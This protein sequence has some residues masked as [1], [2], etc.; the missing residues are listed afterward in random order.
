M[1]LVIKAIRQLGLRPVG[2]L[3]L[4]R[5]SLAS[6]FYRWTENGIEEDNRLSANVF[7]IQKIF[8]LP[9]RDILLACLSKKDLQRLRSEADEIVDGK[10][11]LF[12]GDAV[13]LKLKPEA[14]LSHWTDYETGKTAVDGDIKMTWEP[15]RFGWA[16]TLAR[17]F[18][19]CKDSKYAI[20]FWR[21]TASFLEANPPYKGPQ[22]MSGQ[23]AAL[24]LMGLTFAAQV[25]ASA[26][27][28][29]P[30][31]I[32]ALGKVI[33]V[34][35]RRIV[36]TL[37]YARSQNNNHLLSEA[38]GLITAALVLP[39]HPQASRWLWLGWKWFNQGLETQIND[40]GVYIQ[41]STNYQ[42]LMLQLALWVNLISQHQTKVEKPGDGKIEGS[43]ISDANVKRLNDATFWLMSLV[44]KQS[45]HCPNLGPNDG[46][47]IQPLSL[48]SIDDYRPV[49]Q[50][51]AMIF[52]GIVLPVFGNGAWDEMSVWYGAKAPELEKPKP[53]GKI[54]EGGAP[55]VLRN[56]VSESW[57]YLR[58]ANYQNRPGHAD[59]LHFD[60]WRQGINIVQ[61][62]GTFSYNHPSPWDNTLAKS[63]VHNTITVNG[64]D[65]MTRAGKFLWLDWAQAK[66]VKI[67][68]EENGE[69]WQISAE[70]D[71]YR[72]LG[73]I[74][75][76][77]VSAQTDGS[78]LIEDKL[79]PSYTTKNLEVRFSLRL[80]W[81]FCS[82]PWEW[83]NGS[84]T[85][86]TKKGICTVEIHA[87]LPI[88]QYQIIRGGE[89]LVGQGDFSPTCGWASPTYGKKEP[90]ISLSAVIVAKLPVQIST[91]I[92]FHNY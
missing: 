71:G 53:E 16:Y 48:C 87:D 10:V 85:L 24:R 65:Q 86:F 72:H 88:S 57:G 49:M 78:W 89:L 43:K 52:G 69:F 67:A 12:G 61:D 75:R 1:L 59:Q 77:S 58:I 37:V 54:K 76:R 68:Q 84:L 60:L 74:H 9:P 18:Y 79:T 34:H 40:E 56:P 13:D 46:A 70:H 44:D 2:L 63:D 91:H 90:A 39:H 80:H 83:E 3:S 25:F 17:A 29:V 62:A 8:D 28:T 14:P 33:A 51:S 7:R 32:A 42:R 27:I 5:L 11:R 20:A 26:E 81:L 41:H 64:M 36:P 22:W 15:A 82:A 6:G 4:Y 55:H 38:A 31:Q 45:G 21:L 19:I 50:A 30:K 35:A 92:C 47:Y 73:V 23:E 66:V